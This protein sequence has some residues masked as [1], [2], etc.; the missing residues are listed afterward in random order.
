MYSVHYSALISEIVELCATF[1]KIVR[2]TFDDRS[3]FANWAWI[4]HALY[5]VIYYITDV[6]HKH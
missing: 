3:I 1:W 4:M 6:L 2:S 5:L